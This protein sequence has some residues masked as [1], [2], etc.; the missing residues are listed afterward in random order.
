[1]EACATIYQ[2]CWYMEEDN[3]VKGLS[4]ERRYTM[5][6]HF[7]FPHS[8]FMQIPEPRIIRI[9]QFGVYVSMSVSGFGMLNRPPNSF[10]SVVGLP[11]VYVF[12]SFITLGAVLGAVAVLPGI[13]WLER[14]AIIALCTGLAMYIVILIPV[15]LSP[16][17]TFVSI[18]LI[19]TFLQ[20][21]SEIKGAQLA[22]KEPREG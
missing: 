3:L 13:W 8:L 6:K 1:M 15:A 12:A 18:A 21:W 11:L 22:P 4:Y 7:R 19:L 16:V 9:M 5:K 17:G 10:E 20:R 14:T 2:S